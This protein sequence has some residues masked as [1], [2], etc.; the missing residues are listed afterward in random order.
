MDIEPIVESQET[1][2]MG[3]P[4]SDPMANMLRSMYQEMVAN[5]YG[6]S[7]EDW[8]KEL[9]ENMNERLGEA[10]IVIENKE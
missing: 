7:F 10:A 2:V 9:R 6:G 1:S 5:N 4:V 8:L 3:L